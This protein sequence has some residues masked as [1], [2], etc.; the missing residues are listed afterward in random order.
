MKHPYNVYT[1]SV[2][3]YRERIYIQGSIY[4]YIFVA[5]IVVEDCG[6][7]SGDGVRHCSDLIHTVM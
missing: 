2:S 5:Y 3:A 1:H 6:A 7:A 4:I